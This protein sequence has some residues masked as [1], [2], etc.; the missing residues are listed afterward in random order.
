MSLSL[1]Y[2]KSDV[3]SYVIYALLSFIN[4]TIW[5]YQEEK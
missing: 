3:S 2:L 5:E 4:Q 1:L